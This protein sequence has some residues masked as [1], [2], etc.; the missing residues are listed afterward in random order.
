MK[1]LK[2]VVVMA[3]LVSLSATTSL[4]GKK[5]DTFQNWAEEDQAYKKVWFGS[6]NAS[7][8]NFNKLGSELPG[9]EPPC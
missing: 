3:L 1:V 2:F 9:Q 7:M 8:K 6:P 5:H 4:A